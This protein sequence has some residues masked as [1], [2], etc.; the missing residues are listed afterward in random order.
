M[1][2]QR[3]QQISA[4]I[5]C[6]HKTT[7]ALVTLANRRTDVKRRGSLCACYNTRSLCLAKNT[8][9]SEKDQPEVPMAAF[10]LLRAPSFLTSFG[11][12]EILGIEGRNDQESAV[13][14]VR[15]RIRGAERRWSV[16]TRSALLTTFSPRSAAIAVLSWSFPL[17]RSPVALGHPALPAAGG[18]GDR[19]HE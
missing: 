15:G 17:L 2:Q 18:P 8:K 19:P 14:L 3:E 4:R 5:E 10:E 9:A 7:P 11:P 16:F 13:A 12:F 6:V 1:H